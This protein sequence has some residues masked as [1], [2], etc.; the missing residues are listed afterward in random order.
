MD[1]SCFVSAHAFRRGDKLLLN[2]GFSRCGPFATIRSMAV[3]SRNADVGNIEA[4][5]R[6]FFIT[7]SIEGKR[8]LLQ[9][10][11]SAKLLIEVL[12]QYRGQKKFL[13]HEFVVMP[14]H[15]HLL[16]TVGSD[17]SIE[18]AIQFVKGGFAF[19]AGRELGFRAPV[20]QKGFSDSRIHDREDYEARRTYIHQNPV[21]RGLVSS[22]EEFRFSSAHAG[23]ELDPSPF[24][25]AAK[26]V[27]F[28][29]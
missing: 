6:T 14:N 2:S 17:L 4:D 21:T 12:Y 18:R 19:R 15:I 26:A 9:S 10:D 13:L 29:G 23:F 16:L 20:W 28:K 11:R 25:S 22:P 5:L 24:T 27:S 8:A 1:E 3:P 7:T